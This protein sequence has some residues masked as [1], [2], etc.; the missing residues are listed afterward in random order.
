MLK[1]ENQNETRFDTH[2]I[3]FQRDSY[4]GRF[5][6]QRFRNHEGLVIPVLRSAHQDL[7]H[8]L[9]RNLGPPPKP[10]TEMMQGCIDTLDQEDLS[11]LE[12]DPFYAL[13]AVINYLDVYKELTEDSE[14][15]T[16]AE[17][18]QRNLGFQAMALSNKTFVE[19]QQNEQ[20]EELYPS[21]FMTHDLLLRANEGVPQEL[22]SIHGAQRATVQ[23]IN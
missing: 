3:F 14:V 13:N 8:Y 7:H 12:I 9:E 23:R 11:I 16:Q 17:M 21:T 22:L 20:R 6:Q 15:A 4:Q 5:E 18:I 2:H 1:T 10:T 19:V